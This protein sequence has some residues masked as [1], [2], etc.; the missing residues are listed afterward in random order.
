MDPAQTIV[1]Q[2][3]WEEYAAHRLMD[4]SNYADRLRIY[5]EIYSRDN[6]FWLEKVGQHGMSGQCS[7]NHG[8]LRQ[9]FPGQ[10]PVLDVGGGLGLAGEAF[11]SSRLYAV[12]DAAPVSYGGA[13]APRLVAGYATELPFPD[14]SFEA[15]LILDVLE[16]LHREDLDRAVRE[17]RRVLRPRG[18]LLMATPNRLSGPWDC[19]GAVDSPTATLGLHLNE[20]T[21]ADMI[22]LAKQNGLFPLAFAV[23]EKRALWFHRPISAWAAL[24]EHLTAL[25]PRRLRGRLCRLAILLAEVR[26]ERDASSVETPTVA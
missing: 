17:A 26:E 12:C 15:V 18:R 22:V 11:D 13:R 1:L 21:I 3:R 6:A 7:R 4:A 23:K 9:A 25:A 2:Q 10:G 8:L 16:H 19:R 24:W 5:R 20:L 14:Q